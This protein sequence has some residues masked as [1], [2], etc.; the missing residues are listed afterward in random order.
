M[1]QQM[2]STRIMS[3]N[4]VII[5][6]SALRSLGDKM[7]TK[8][9]IFLVLYPTLRSAS[10]GK[11]RRSRIVG[12]C[13]THYI[14]K[15]MYRSAPLLKKGVAKYAL[16]IENPARFTHSCCSAVSWHSKLAY[17]SSASV[18]IGFIITFTR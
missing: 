14:P 13:Q 8:S 2:N 9:C 4:L 17:A 15:G 11:P 7:G 18:R 3:Q 10:E 5:S 12:S 16:P 1:P 6:I